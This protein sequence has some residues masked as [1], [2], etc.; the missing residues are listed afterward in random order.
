MSSGRSFLATAA[1]PK[2]SFVPLRGTNSPYRR[3]V[4]VDDG[5]AKL[6]EPNPQT[7]PTPKSS[8]PN[9]KFTENPSKQLLGINLSDNF[10]YGVECAS[11]LD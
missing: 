4:R 2:G 6:A 9:T 7:S 3:R 11:E 8:F 10:S 1:K 5:R